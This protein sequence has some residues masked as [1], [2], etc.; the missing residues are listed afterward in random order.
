MALIHIKRE[1]GLSLEQARQKVE[2]LAQ[3]LE[4]ELKV[5]HSWDGNVL[6]FKRT[7]ATGA[8]GVS[9]KSVEVKIK[10]GMVLVPMKSKIERAINDSLDGLRTSD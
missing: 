5:Q 9:D 6:R 3:S 7:G 4:E 8:V 2:D 1:H 10:L